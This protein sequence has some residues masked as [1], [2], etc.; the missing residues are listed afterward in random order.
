MAGDDP[1]CGRGH[2]VH[3]APAEIHD[4]LRVAHRPARGVA[5][6][7]GIRRARR[8][9]PRECGAMRGGDASLAPLPTA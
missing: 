5:L 8:I 2:L 6:M 7:P 3:G 1:L 4:L 9:P